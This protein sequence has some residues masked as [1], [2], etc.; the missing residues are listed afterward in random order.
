MS[1]PSSAHAAQLIGT[2]KAVSFAGID[3]QTGAQTRAFGEHPKGYLIFQPGRMFAFIS[4]EGVPPRPGAEAGAPRPS[5]MA[6][7]GPYAVSEDSFV[8]MVDMSAFQCWIG[9]EQKR[10]FKIGGDR[11]EITTPTMTRPDGAKVHSLLIW[12][13]DS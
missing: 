7:S 10:F 1:P 8:T 6:Y 2:W 13:R 4:F 12:R 9:T 11:L 3:E 5:M